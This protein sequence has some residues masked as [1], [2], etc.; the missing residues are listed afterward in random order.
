[1]FSPVIIMNHITASNTSATAIILAHNGICFLD[2][3]SSNLSTCLH[4]YDLAV[5]HDA[6][7][8]V[9]IENL[10]LSS[11]S[12]N[13]LV[14]LFQSVNP[15]LFKVNIHKTMAALLTRFH[16]I[17]LICPIFLFFVDITLFLFAYVHLLRDA[18]IRCTGCRPI[19]EKNPSQ[20]FVSE[21]WLGFFSFTRL[22]AFSSIFK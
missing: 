9:F 19:K 2:R 10:T 18:S 1:M 20:V 13:I 6:T 21:T 17:Y 4:P 11:C 5:L 12:S 16:I 7:Y 15:Q 3:P 8:Q 22:V 14:L